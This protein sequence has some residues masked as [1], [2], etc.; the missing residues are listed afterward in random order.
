MKS[1][2]Y[3]EYNQGHFSILKQLGTGSYGSVDLCRDNAT[4]KEFV[5]KKVHAN[6]ILYMYITWLSYRQ[7]YSSL[8]KKGT[9]YL[10]DCFSFITL[11]YAIW[12]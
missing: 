9:F 1:S 2:H 6:C 5:L 7:I 11:S 8:S 4:T 10:S 3:D 12:I